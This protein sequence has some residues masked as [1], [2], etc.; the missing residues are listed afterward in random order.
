MSATL[1]AAYASRWSTRAF[2]TNLSLLTT[3]DEGV[4][5][6]AESA[7]IESTNNVR[8]LPA[9]VANPIAGLL[10]WDP[11]RVFDNLTPF[12]TSFHRTDTGY[13]IELPVPGFAS[14]Q[15]DLSYHDGVVQLNCKNDRRQLNQ[16]FILPD[17][18]DP[19]KIEAHVSNGMLELH[20]E[21]QEQSKPKKIAI[22]SG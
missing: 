3:T 21:R 16:S 7:T 12:G 2:C 13:D 17:D 22:V 15:V 4:I 19:E 5:S 9:A 6:V 11:F 20:V 18:A 10:S 1:Q 8:R 14:D